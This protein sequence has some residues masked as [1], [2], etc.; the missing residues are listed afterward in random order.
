MISSQGRYPNIFIEGG[1][2]GKNQNG[3]F[4]NDSYPY[5]G[6]PYSSLNLIDRHLID[7]YR[8]RFQPSLQ[9]GKRVIAIWLTTSSTLPSN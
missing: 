7:A 1:M 3:D 5:R 8:E 9:I 6:R 2:V 4:T